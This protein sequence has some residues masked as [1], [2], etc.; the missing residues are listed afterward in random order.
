MS[1]AV[2]RA[3]PELT[4]PEAERLEACLL[5]AARA[6]IGAEAVAGVDRRPLDATWYRTE[7]VSATLASGEVV[8]CFVKDFGS[9]ERT[10]SRMEER[11]ERELTF[12]R[13]VFPSGE[14]G[15]PFYAGEV[16]RGGSAWLV[17]EHVEAV[18][19]RWCDLDR[20]REAAVWLG[21][22]QTAFEARRA[23][24]PAAGVFERRRE[25]FEN[26][27]RRA[28]S[29]AAGYGDEVETRLRAA[30]PLYR[31][32]VRSL[33]AQPQTLV[34]GAFRPAQVLVAGGQPPRICPV[35]WEICG[36]GSCLYDLATLADGFAPEEADVFLDRYLDEASWLPEPVT[37]DDLRAALAACRM[38]R[39]MKWI[40]HARARGI[41][42][43]DV[44][45]LARSLDAPE[46]A[47]T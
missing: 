2:P 24:L 7:V 16:P 37:R 10:K 42:A 14:L 47:T 36:I 39:T 3:F 26:V 30:A 31:E 38:H 13:D 5:R 44:V 18:P 4:R 1:G 9:Y 35:D 8:R 21:R 17:L 12:Y 20:W 32:L 22:F 23:T 43:D 11:R 28:T 46:G 25:Y 34:H 29:E 15:L 33:K 6:G 19:L 41:P 40:G 27:L 45:A